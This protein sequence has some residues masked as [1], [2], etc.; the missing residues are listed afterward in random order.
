MKEA[1]KGQKKASRCEDQ[2]SQLAERVAAFTH[3]LRKEIRK[4]KVY[5]HDIKT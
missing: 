1:E 3:D 5:W 2:F 4:R